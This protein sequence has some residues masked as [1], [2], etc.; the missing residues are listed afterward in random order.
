MQSGGE[1]DWFPAILTGGR[2]MAIYRPTKRTEPYLF[3]MPTIV[4]FAAFLFVPLA[5]LV[6]YS[7][8]KVDMVN[9]FE[10]WVGLANYKQLFTKDFLE[11][12]G[13]TMIW[14]MGSMIPMIVFGIALAL[15]LHKPMPG[16]HLFRI[17]AIV[18]W[19]IPEAFSAT[20]WLW[21]FNPQYGLVNNVLLKTGII[22]QPIGFLTTSSAMLTVIVVRVWKGTPF[23][24]MTAL[25]ALQTIPKDVE[26]AAALDGATR[27]RYFFHVVF[28]FLRP[29]LLVS[30]LILSAWTLKIFD[31]IFVMT[32]G[33][34]M[35][36]T[37][38]ISI[39]IYDKAFV[40][41]D[42]GEASVFAI[43]TLLL[44]LLLSM[45]TFNKQGDES[46]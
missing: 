32:H 12:L 4:F 41:S 28:P 18:P 6:R 3:L 36:Q 43:V 1:C 15:L 29:V 38:I 2:C 20:M 19:L 30:A 35:R 26:E 45:F 23:I 10:G 13:R 33:G 7:F 9:G 8:A 40:N 16:I 37:E 25:A 17:V 31:T 46:K 44:V 27:W 42:L 11:I 5:D 14:L 24:I 21:V 39:A 22:H 34:P